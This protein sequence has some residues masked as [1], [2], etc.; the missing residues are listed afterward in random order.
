[1][2]IPLLVPLE[3]S[4]P[5]LPLVPVQCDELWDDVLAS[6]ESPLTAASM[7]LPPL[8]RRS[9][10]L[11]M[12]VS[13]LAVGGLLLVAL[14]IFIATEVWQSV[15]SAPS[16]APPP[17]AQAVPS[18]RPRTLPQPLSPAVPVARPEAA[19][20]PVTSGPLPVWSPDPALLEQLGPY[21]D[22]GDYQIRVPKGYTRVPPPLGAPPGGQVF[23]WAGTVRP[24][25]HRPAIMM[26]VAV[27]PPQERLASGDQV[28]NQMF[29][30]KRG[31]IPNVTPKA[32]QSG[33]VNGLTFARANWEGIGMGPGMGG[34][35]LHG[36]DYVCVDGSTVIFLHCQ[37]VEPY[38]GQSLALGQA[39][40]L[41]FR[42][43]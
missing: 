36:W 2:A 4:P 20:N 41:T 10:G 35:R 25:G 21:Q 16:D 40:V 23:R 24:D 22:C 5:P 14:G 32:V 43:K 39:A 15:P 13:L 3:E 34:Q 26:A 30:E 28:L 19:A 31:D 18:L 8:P 33:Q 27:P 1:M 12:V 37:D 29:S 17:Q 6:A 42:K 38:Q 9:Q 11:W 7:Q